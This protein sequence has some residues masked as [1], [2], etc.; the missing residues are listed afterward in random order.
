MASKIHYDRQSASRVFTVLHIVPIVNALP[1]TLV[2]GPGGQFHDGT[3]EFHI[4]VGDCPVFVQ[5]L[6]G[7][8]MPLV[9]VGGEIAGPAPA[10]EGAAAQRPA[11]AGHA[12]GADLV[13]AS[14]DG[15]PLRARR[16]LREKESKFTGGNHQAVAGEIELAAGPARKADGRQPGDVAL[17]LRK[18]VAHPA[19]ELRLAAA[20]FHGI[21]QR[22][23]AG[24]G[25]ATRKSR[26]AG[27]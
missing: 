2:A 4:D 10:E 14:S 25:L 24:V 27:R 9:R 11:L 19:K 22:H 23:S 20:E 18:D 21:G 8:V 1:Q 6:E 5:T 17:G 12:R 13:R 3:G 7:R 26:F 16:R 15:G